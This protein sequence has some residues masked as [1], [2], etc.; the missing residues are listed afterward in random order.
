MNGRNELHLCT[1]EMMVAVQE[2]LNKRMAAYAPA[3]TGIRAKDGSTAPTF[4][5]LLEAKE[6]TDG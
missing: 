6:P 1:A 4:V 2:Y 3:V 5:I